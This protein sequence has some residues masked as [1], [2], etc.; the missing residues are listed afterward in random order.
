M[1]KKRDI[2]KERDFWAG[3]ILKRLIEG[4][5]NGGIFTMITTILQQAKEGE[6]YDND[7]SKK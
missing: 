2:D 6:W 4:Q 7:Y 1:H 3:Y 5:L